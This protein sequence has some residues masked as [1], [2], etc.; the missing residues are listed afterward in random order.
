MKSSSFA[1]AFEDLL[2]GRRPAWYVVGGDRERLV[3]AC[4]DWLTP[5]RVSTRD[6]SDPTPHRATWILDRL[7]P[8]DEIELFRRLNS[9]T[10][11]LPSL[12]ALFRRS[13]ADMDS[14]TAERFGHGES[15]AVETAWVDTRASDDDLLGWHAECLRRGWPADSLH[16]PPVA[17]VEYCR[18]APDS[19]R[20]VSYLEDAPVHE[21][22]VILHRLMRLVAG[23]VPRTEE[24]EPGLETRLTEAGFE[25][26]A[27]AVAARIKPRPA[28]PIIEV[29][30][31]FG[32]GVS[33]SDL[34]ESNFTQTLW[35][36]QQTADDV[37]R[38][39]AVAPYIA[40][41]RLGEIIPSD[42]PDLWERVF[43]AAPDAGASLLKAFCRWC[44]TTQMHLLVP[45]FDHEDRECAA[46]AFEAFLAL[47]PPDEV[48]DLAEERDRA[49]WQ[50]ELLDRWMHAPPELRPP[51]RTVCGPA[52]IVN[53]MW[54]ADPFDLRLR[55]DA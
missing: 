6:F 12:Y 53:S 7:L 42:R 13:P 14:V 54:N 1:G 33:D 51:E 15:D 28:V 30:L 45:Y 39:V 29:E 5:E 49:D 10:R 9:Y 22:P 32:R 21:V 41:W 48:E 4:I 26:L 17:V 43:K 31:V 52:E 2:Y 40:E 44:T 20:L 11:W 23:S 37:D 36:A 18:R 25:T 34:W 46:S 50:I 38:L 47:A 24:P 3:A 16:F 55:R 19:A 27:K 35:I 8:L